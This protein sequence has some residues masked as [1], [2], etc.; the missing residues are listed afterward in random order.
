MF[1]D[2]D[3]PEL[4]TQ[5]AVLY[6]WYNGSA[7]LPHYDV[8]E[9]SI[10]YYCATFKTTVSGDKVKIK[11]ENLELFYWLRFNV[12]VRTFMVLEND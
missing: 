10:R 8:V 3:A 6:S 7:L 5:S 1:V 2:T 12:S 4:S 9:D 11:Y